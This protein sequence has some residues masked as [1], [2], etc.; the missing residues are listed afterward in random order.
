M[1]FRNPEL[2]W[3]LLLLPL[4]AWYFWKVK[5]RKRPRIQISSTEA[6]RHYR[7]TL[8]QRLINLPIG[9]RVLAVAFLIVALARPQSSSKAS[10]VK[11]EGI[12]IVL[13][14]DISSS[15]V[16]EDFRPNRIEA[17]KKVALDFIDGRPNDL[18]GL[19][20]FS[21]ESFTQC[22]ITSDH[23]VL[24]S[25]V[26]AVKP[27]MVKDGTAIGD[28]LAT[29]VD[30]VK[31]SPTKSKVVVLITDGVNNSGS[32]PPLTAGEI[33]KT[34]GV[35]VYSIGVGTRGMAPYPQKT[36]FGIQYQNVEVQ[37][38]E[39]LLTQV[40]DA[41]DGR[42]YRAVNNKR[43]QA[44]FEEI[45]KLEKSKI[46]VTEFKRYTEEYLP[47]ALVALFFFLLEVVLRY[48]WLRSLP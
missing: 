18:I 3:L 41:T 1:H 17:A 13:A 6:F 26:K 4:M 45:D 24:K 25:M 8:R 19:V 15:I 33:A 46:E 31:E 44:I 10:N 37:I 23:T 36:L 39:D 28:G 16:A 40:A 38:D 42:Y 48:T 35:R 21:G 9:L 32:I 22:P 14:L 29:A 20:I 34:F 43:L 2:L 27:G 7:P 12:S 30:R 11:T 5:R 47:F